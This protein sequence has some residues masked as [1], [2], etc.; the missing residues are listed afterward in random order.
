MAERSDIQYIWSLLPRLVIVDF[1]SNEVILQDLHDTTVKAERSTNGMDEK[2]LIS[3]GGKET[4]D[5]SGN[6]VGITST[7]LQ[8]KLLFEERT[9]SVSQ[10]TVTA[11][12]SNGKTLRDTAATFITD[13][14]EQGAVAINLDDFSVGTVVTIDSE[15]QLTLLNRLDDG[16]DNEF[17]VGDN[18][19]IWN[20]EQCSVVGGNLVAE[21]AFEAG[22]GNPIPAIFPTFGT[23]I[24]L[25]SSSSATLQ[26]LTAIQF[27]SYNGGISWDPTNSSGRAVSG[28]GYPAGTPEQ[29]CLNMSDVLT[30]HSGLG[31]NTVYILG[32]A[33]L[34]ADAS[35]P[36]LTYV[37]E[38]ETE[39]TITILGAANTS[40]SNFRE[41]LVTGE[42]DGDAN[43]ADCILQDL[44]M[45]NGEA[46][47][48]GIRG[49]IT[50]SG[51]SVV[52]FIDCHGAED[53]FASPPT[54]DL[55][56]SNGPNC[57]VLGYKG[58]L[59]FENC[60]RAGAQTSC[61]LA[62][63]AA[64]LDSASFTHGIFAASGTGSLLNETNRP[65]KSRQPFNNVI[66]DNGLIT[67]EIE[68]ILSNR[69]KIDT[70]RN[71][72]IIMDPDG[73]TERYNWDSFDRNGTA[74]VLE[75]FERIINYNLGP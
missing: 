41:A 20:I 21:D 51:S 65:L 44:T 70:A 17:Q 75:I 52:R 28:T 31:L 36:N 43:F 14:V 3:S 58:S 60:T 55:G 64:F 5:A 47:R 13:G 68:M 7:L 38:G 1:P 62:G 67:P 6:K 16:D 11:A 37:G 72:I 32:N 54:L 71:Q 34:D 39:T 15:T 18:Y 63:G 50:L 12:D 40:D 57:F 73:V 53:S 29:P 25:T 19:K 49:T 2:E 23:Q 9:A 59:R 26:E 46:K 61:I 74:S 45:F 8:G 69:L 33:T 42:L 4:L 35:V 22:T 66:I 10:G 30:I 24:L 27:A 56:G 48:C